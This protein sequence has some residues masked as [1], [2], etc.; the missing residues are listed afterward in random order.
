MARGYWHA[1]NSTWERVTEAPE[2][3]VF[4]KVAG[5]PQGGVSPT[6]GVIV[7]VLVGEVV[8]VGLSTEPGQ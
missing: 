5:A 2:V 1:R 8:G 6:V 3:F 4:P 7:G